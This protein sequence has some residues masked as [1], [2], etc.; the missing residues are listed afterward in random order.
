M[1][2]SWLAC[3]QAR[4]K[5]CQSPKRPSSCLVPVRKR[6][7]SCLVPVRMP[8]K[9][10]PSFVQARGILPVAE[11]QSRTRGS[12]SSCVEDQPQ[13]RGLWHSSSPSAHSLSRSPS[14]PLLLSHNL[15]L[16]RV[17][18]LPPKT[19]KPTCLPYCH[20]AIKAFIAIC[21]ATPLRA[22]SP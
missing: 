21:A 6:P 4:N 18:K 7:S 9:G 5:Q 13:C 16:P 1:V 12:Q 17:H 14:P 3:A 20:I 19:W 10:L 8:T 11:E 15:P 22:R 2:T